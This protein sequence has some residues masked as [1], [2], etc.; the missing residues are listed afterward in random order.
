MAEGEARTRTL[1]SI[2]SN[3]IGTDPAAATAAAARL[4]GEERDN[5]MRSVA[6]SLAWRDPQKAISQASNIQDENQRKSII[7]NALGNM[8][9]SNPQQAIATLN[10]LGMGGDA[11]A[12]G[13][14]V[15]RWSSNNITAASEWVKKL[16]GGEV[17]DNALGRVAQQLA[18]DEPE[19]AIAWAQSIGDEKSRQNNIQNVVWQWKRYEPQAA[20]AWVASSNLPADVKERLMK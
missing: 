8:A 12:V 9:N 13:N 5:V 4:T 6:N 10:S 2:F 1:D 17:R 20:K 15:D 7:Q 11:Q 3:W 18:G 19:T 16:P 14:I